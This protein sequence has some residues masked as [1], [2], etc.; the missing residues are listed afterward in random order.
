[1]T[2]VLLAKAKE[3]WEEL[4]LM[5]IPQALADIQEV[6]LFIKVDPMI[7]HLMLHPLDAS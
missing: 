1:M 2:M 6:Y 5:A 3:L 7:I 4:S